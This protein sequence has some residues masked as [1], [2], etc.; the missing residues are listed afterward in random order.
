MLCPIFYNFRSISNQI[1]KL[2]DRPQ[3]LLVPDY[4]LV[5][6]RSGRDHMEDW[7]KS[8]FLPHN[9][10]VMGAN[11]SLPHLSSYLP[12]DKIKIFSHSTICSPLP[13]SI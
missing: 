6:D 9:P 13:T 11:G 8:C 1:T 5:G 12:G 10:R 4:F 3:S 7:G 2:S